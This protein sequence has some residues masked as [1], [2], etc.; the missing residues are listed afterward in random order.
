MRLAASTTLD[1]VHD[2]LQ[3]AM[4]WEN[5]HLHA[6]MVGAQSLRNDVY[7]S[8]PTRFHAG[9]VLDDRKARLDAM[10]R[11]PKRRIRYT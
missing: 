11:K 10:L 6:F 2:V 7:F 5:D 3:I 8:D 1:D 4:G 9:D